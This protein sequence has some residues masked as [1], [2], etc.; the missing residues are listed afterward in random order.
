MAAHGWLV[1][2][3]QSVPLFQSNEVP[4][5]GQMYSPDP[6]RSGFVHPRD[7]RVGRPQACLLAIGFCEPG[8]IGRSLVKLLSRHLIAAALGTHHLDSGLLRIEK[9]PL[10]IRPATR[11]RHLMLISF[12]A[13]HNA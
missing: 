5:Y 4:R 8:T 13:V 11:A 9:G 6:K 12:F 10:R 2:L 3:E 1:K 7:P